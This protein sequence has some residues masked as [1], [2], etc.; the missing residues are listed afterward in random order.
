M[1][2]LD[3]LWVTWLFLTITWAFTKVINQNAT[4]FWM[5]SIHLVMMKKADY[6]AEYTLMN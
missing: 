1:P 4:A 3:G 2:S 6:T 5:L